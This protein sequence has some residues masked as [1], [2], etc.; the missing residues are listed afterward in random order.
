VVAGAAATYVRKGESESWPMPGASPDSRELTI[1]GAVPGQVCIR[2]GGA[3]RIQQGV[4]VAADLIR[5][6]SGPPAAAVSFDGRRLTSWDSSLVTFAYGVT[7]ELRQRGLAVDLEGL[8]DGVRRLLALATIR[9][10]TAAAAPSRQ[11]RP[12]LVSIGDRVLTRTSG[13]RSELALIGEVATAFG[14]L[15][16][17][18]ARVRGGD[19]VSEIREAGARALGIVTLT[20][21]LLGMI[22]AFVGAAALRP[23]GAGIFVANVVALAMVRELAAVLT[24]I[25]MAGRTG[26]SYGAQLATMN[27]TQELDALQTMGVDPID[28]LVLPRMVALSLMQPL[29]CVYSGF[30]GIAG[31]A[32]VA[33]SMLDLTVDQ[34]LHQTRAAVSLTTFFIGIGKSG[35]FG[36]LVAFLGCRAGLRSGRDAAAVGRAATR[37][38]VSA[39]LAIIAAD[40]ACAVIFQVLGV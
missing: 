23:F 26:S 9:P 30:V 11:R 15:V 24:A 5:L 34:Y 29:L 37:A 1:S 13:L 38:M 8:P 39:I 35:L 19:V 4:P 32:L 33:V 16:T 40:G 10:E 18:R 27:L 21:F 22:M 6:A 20:S 36:L 2:I 28:F 7:E 31:G 17:G 3:W 25:L 12:W 14:R